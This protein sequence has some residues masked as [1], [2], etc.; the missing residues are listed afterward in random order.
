MLL[1]LLVDLDLKTVYNELATLRYKS[2]K[3][4]MQLGIAYHKLKEFEKETDPLSA[5]INHWLSGN[6]SPLSWWSIVTALQSSAVG[7]SGLAGEI[8]EK[9]CSK[10]P[11][12]H[13]Q[14]LM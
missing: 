13:E 1:S 3:I 10:S 8:E 6:G 11:T 7:E 4:G 14:R 9:Y 12:K 5:I 2:F